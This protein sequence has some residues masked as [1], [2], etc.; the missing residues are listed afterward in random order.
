LDQAGT[1]FGAA[2]RDARQSARRHRVADRGSGH[3]VEHDGT[4]VGIAEASNPALRP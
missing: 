4:S 3:L 1:A 2:N